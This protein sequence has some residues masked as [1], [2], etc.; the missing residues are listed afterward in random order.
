MQMNSKNAC[1]WRRVAIWP[2]KINPLGTIL[3]SQTCWD[4]LFV[5][6]SPSFFS[7]KTFPVDWRM[8]LHSLPSRRYLL[9][10]YFYSVVSAAH[11]DEVNRLF[12]VARLDLIWGRGCPGHSWTFSG[13]SC[14]HGFGFPFLVRKENYW[15]VRNHCWFFWGD[16]KNQTLTLLRMTVWN[17]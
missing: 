2:T 13:M 17:Q 4:F 6:Y 12:L 1:R 11:N 8:F 16:Y 15:V 7:N 14:W 9:S 5:S 10:R 3:L